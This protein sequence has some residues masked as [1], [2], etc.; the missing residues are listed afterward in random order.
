MYDE[1][2]FDGLVDS[3][4]SQD[5][6]PSN[7]D[8]KNFD[9]TPNLL[10]LPDMA[11]QPM[12][13]PIDM[14]SVNLG[15]ASASPL[16][17]VDQAYL[18]QL[19]YGNEGINYPTTAST[20]GSGGSPVGSSKEMGVMDYAKEYG[21]HLL[22]PNPLASILISKLSSLLG[23]SIGG[24]EGELSQTAASSLLRGASPQQAL[25]NTALSEAANQ[26]HQGVSSLLPKS[27]NPSLAE[28]YL[29]KAAPNLGSTLITALL[30]GNA[31]SLSPMLKN[32][33]LNTGKGMA[34]D[35]VFGSLTGD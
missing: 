20:Q 35:K 31:G 3:Y 5:S 21:P 18:N 33:L 15:S 6:L 19:N 11:A 26:T 25:A 8:F 24:K 9:F 34:T 14:G 2:D 22:S 7:F 17:S 23:E 32:T 4:G 1:S 13:Q 30:T 12:Q 16:S 27:E 10:N 28:D 29:N